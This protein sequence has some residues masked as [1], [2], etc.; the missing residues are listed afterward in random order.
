MCVCYDPEMWRMSG[1]C[2]VEG[3]RYL[4][5]MGDER[6]SECRTDLKS[7]K[8]IW[9][10]N[11]LSPGRDGFQLPAFVLGDYLWCFARPN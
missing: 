6:V 7:S 3:V 4:G 5:N 10:D 2:T 1:R 9:L 8:L 11:M